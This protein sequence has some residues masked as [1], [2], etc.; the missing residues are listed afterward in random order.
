[1]FATGWCGHGWAIAPVIA[2]ALG[3][4]A[5]TG[6]RPMPLAPF[7]LARFGT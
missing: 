3:A 4:W 5:L 1:L 6:E 7:S 2:D